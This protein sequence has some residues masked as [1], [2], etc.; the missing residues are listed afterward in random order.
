MKIAVSIPD[1]VFAEGEAL[2]LR[3]KTSR[4]KIYAR[5]LSE[6]ALRNNPETL[7]EAY[8]KALAD[9]GD[10]DSAFAKEA[11]RQIFAKSEW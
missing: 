8:D 2:A 10:D 6:F 11:A 7:T 5:A 9:A 4:S 1:D 3:L